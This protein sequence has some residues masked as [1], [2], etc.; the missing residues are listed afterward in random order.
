MTQSPLNSIQFW[1]VY[2][3]VNPLY[4]RVLHSKLYL[5]N[6]KHYYTL[7]KKIHNTLTQQNDK[8]T[9]KLNFLHRKANECETVFDTIVKSETDIIQR[10]STD[11]QPKLASSS[12]PTHEEYDF[13]V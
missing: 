3:N 8:L 5:P 12:S 10:I 6:S 1:T 4:N 9:E 7:Q 13:D 11:I 2:N